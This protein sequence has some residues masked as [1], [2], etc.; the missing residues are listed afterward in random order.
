MHCE[1]IVMNKQES[2]ACQVVLKMLQKELD[3]ADEEWKLDQGSI[4]HNLWQV[5][6]NCVYTLLESDAK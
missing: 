5:A 2:K 3:K 1:R 4:D 6:I